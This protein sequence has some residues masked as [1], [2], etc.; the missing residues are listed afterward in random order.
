M[1]EEEAPPS[2]WKA[3]RLAWE[4]WILAVRKDRGQLQAET[5]ELS[6]KYRAALDHART[7]HPKGRP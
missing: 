4:A 5:K 7:V 1:T 2:P 3:A 6:R